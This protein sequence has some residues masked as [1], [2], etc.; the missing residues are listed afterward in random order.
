MPRNK[1]SDDEIPV[2]DAAEFAERYCKRHG[3]LEA[4][5]VGTSEA[6]RECIRS[7]EEARTAYKTHRDGE[8]E[9]RCEEPSSER[10]ASPRG[11]KRKH[12]TMG[13]DSNL[14][15][16]QKY[17]RR[18]FNNRKSAAA[19]KVYQEVLKREMA[20][21]LARCSG[22]PSSVPQLEEENRRL[23][24]ERDKFVTHNTKL[25]AALMAERKAVMDLKRLLVRTGQRRI[26]LQ[27]DIERLRAVLYAASCSG[28]YKTQPSPIKQDMY[29]PIDDS[30]PA[31]QMCSQEMDMV[32]NIGSQNPLGGNTQQSYGFSQPSA[33]AYLADHVN[34]QQHT[35]GQT[36]SQ[37][38]AGGASQTPSGDATLVETKWP[39]SMALSSMAAEGDAKDFTTGMTCTQSQEGDDKS[40]LER[41]QPLTMS[42][43]V[44]IN[45]L[46]SSQLGS[47]PS[48]DLPP[49]KSTI[50]SEENPLAESDYLLSSQGQT[51]SAAN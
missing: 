31:L 36:D 22:G 28:G 51:K 1:K 5:A 6:E 45:N 8:L 27:S 40:T 33:S 42:N 25:T 9:R 39:N 11:T 21:K 13:E 23:K 15:P 3:L 18:L 26:S 17:A 47:Q 38:Q 43:G 41:P 14:T 37:P 2:A 32:N 29:P 50:G 20:T 48:Q 44:P 30:Q 4:E 16:A 7:A 19:S 34:S 24:E 46:L 35:L 10:S 49:F 12:V